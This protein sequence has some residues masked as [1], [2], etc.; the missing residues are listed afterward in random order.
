MLFS[1]DESSGANATAITGERLVLSCLDEYISKVTW[2]KNGEV[3][4]ETPRARSRIIL[5]N[6]ILKIRSVRL[7]DAGLYTCHLEDWQSIPPYRMNIIVEPELGD[8]PALGPPMAAGLRAQDEYLE[9]P[10]AGYVDG[11]ENAGVHDSELP[12]SP[13]KFTRP[14]EL[15]ES[16]VKPAG[17]SLKLRCPASGNPQPNITWYKNGKE[18]KREHRIN[19]NK[20]TLRMDE[21]N[22][23]DSA[24]YSCV[25]CNGLGCI[26]HTFKIDVVG[27]Y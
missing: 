7:E 20:W 14:D 6:H 12:L 3:I 22:M 13:P 21:V 9:Q 26:S 1:D 18:P 11:N 5:F 10:G 2:T 16:E 23:Q 15:L 24:N 25:V 19:M 8:A 27:E 17:N 4:P